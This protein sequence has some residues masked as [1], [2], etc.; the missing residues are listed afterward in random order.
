MTTII[1]SRSR[2][3]A[4]YSKISVH[5]IRTVIP[6]TNYWENTRDNFNINKIGLKEW[7]TFLLHSF[8]PSFHIGQSIEYNETKH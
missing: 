2:K 8:W 5:M 7:T 1:L 4:L 6:V 3:N